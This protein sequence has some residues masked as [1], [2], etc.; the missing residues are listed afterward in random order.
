MFAISIASFPLR[1]VSTESLGC[2]NSVVAICVLLT[3]AAGVGAVGVPA[4]AG[5]VIVPP[6]IVGV[7]IVGEF[8]S[9]EDKDNGILLVILYG[10]IV[11]AEAVETA[12]ATK[13]LSFCSHAEPL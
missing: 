1:E 7:V 6:V 11:T 13:T 9:G 3:V 4:S 12:F 8:I 5:L 10:V 2:E